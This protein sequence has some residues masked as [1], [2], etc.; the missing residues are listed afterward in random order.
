[1][2]NPGQPREVQD[3]RIVATS[4]AYAAVCAELGVPYVDLFAPLSADA[5]FRKSMAAGDGIHP[6]ADGY[7]LVTELVGGWAGWRAWFDR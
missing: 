3:A 2:L 1:M 4:K 7:A 6:T 5:R